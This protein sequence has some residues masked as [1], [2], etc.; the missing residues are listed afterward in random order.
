MNFVHVH[1]GH[2]RANGDREQEYPG[3]ALEV[4]FTEIHL[5]EAEREETGNWLQWILPS[6]LCRKEVG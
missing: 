5:T 4:K 3:I 2:R 1:L 6:D